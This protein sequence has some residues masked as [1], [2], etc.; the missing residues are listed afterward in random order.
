MSA[1]FL[2]L[3][4][5]CLLLA[6]LA[7]CGGSDPA[8]T[9]QSAVQ[10]MRSAAATTA[11]DYGPVVQQLYIAYFG[12]PADPAALRQFSY[13]LAQY[14]A[15]PDIVALNAAY[16]ENAGIRA[17][18]DS[19]AN[20]EESQGLYPPTATTASFV[21]AIYFNGLGRLPED[22][23]PGKAYWVNAIDQK[24]LTRTKAALS[25]LAGAQQ[26]KSPQGLLDAKT[27]SNKATVAAA[28]TATVPEQVY[29][30]DVAG[31]MARILIFHVN[32]S[33]LVED[34]YKAEIQTVIEELN[35]LAYFP[36]F[37]GNYEGSLAGGDQGSFTFSIAQDGKVSG[38]G[39]TG[40]L[41]QQNVFGQLKKPDAN[42]TTMLAYFGPYPF[43]GT[44]TAE[45]KLIGTWSGPD[46]QGSIT[47]TRK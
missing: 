5:A 21:T 31:R 44:L 3:C 25:L 39:Q 27:I 29:R 36:A 46:I 15:P 43:S 8:T 17:L 13:Q 11:V 47:A 32:S 23:D 33:E 26:N 34:E 30:G 28:F 2:R 41:G 19:F 20:S 4:G 35:R 40:R 42:T 24:R 22:D 6:S 38:S 18:V 14:G 45:G 12:R 37:V 1:L 16:Q 10:G 9:R 7:S